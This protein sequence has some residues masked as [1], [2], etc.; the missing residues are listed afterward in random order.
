MVENTDWLVV[1]PYW[2]T[3]PYQTLLLPRRHV[4][5]LQDLCDSERDS[6]WLHILSAPIP[7]PLDS[8]F[9]VR[10]LYGSLAGAGGF[11]SLWGV[12]RLGSAC[13]GTVTPITPGQGLGVQAQAVLV[14]GLVL[15]LG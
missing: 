11:V 6:E 10:Q 13:G 8:A 4:C 1:V 3:W 7:H 14:E 5:R 2:A 12:G 15:V 9:V